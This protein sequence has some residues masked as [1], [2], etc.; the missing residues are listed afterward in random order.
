MQDRFED[1]FPGFIVTH[2]A[3]YADSAMNQ[4]YTGEVMVGFY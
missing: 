1:T 2:D 4:E 3:W